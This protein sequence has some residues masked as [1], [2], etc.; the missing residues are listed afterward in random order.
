MA[1]LKLCRCG[2]VIPAGNKHCEQCAATYD[3]ERHKLYDKHRRDKVSAAFYN[4]KPWKITS[5]DVRVRD[6]HMCQL[7]F[8]NNKIKPVDVVHHIKELRESPRLALVKTNLISLCAACHRHVHVEYEKGAS[9]KKKMEEVLR[10][11][12]SKYGP[13]A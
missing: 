10:G 5:A 4:G 13:P 9:E 6:D 2:K 3:K 7:C 1:M 12:L 8:I 11:I